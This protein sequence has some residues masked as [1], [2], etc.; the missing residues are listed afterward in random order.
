VIPDN[1]SRKGAHALALRLQRYWAE[2]GYVVECRVRIVRDVNG[3]L[4]YTVESDMINGRPRRKV[5]N[6]G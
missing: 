1:L 3:D 2:R 5:N 6:Y 4:A